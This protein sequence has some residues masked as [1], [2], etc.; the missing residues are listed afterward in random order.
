[1]KKVLLGAILLGGTTLGFAKE[2][3]VN[4]KTNVDSKTKEQKEI[5]VQLRKICTTI[6]SWTTETTSVGMDGQTYVNTQQHTAQTSSW[7]GANDP[8]TTF[9]DGNPNP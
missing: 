2:N 1:M 4:I 8:R 7:C 9:V 6:W 5:D 3:V